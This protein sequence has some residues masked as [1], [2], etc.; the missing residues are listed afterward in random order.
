M[1]F[2]ITLKERRKVILQTKHDFDIMLNG[3]VFGQLTYNMTGYIGYLPLP[4]GGKMDFGETGITAY[5][6]T[7]AS[8]NREARLM[9]CAA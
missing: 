7:I 6:R 9:E 8:L 1:A 2:K 4:E 3:K 5:R